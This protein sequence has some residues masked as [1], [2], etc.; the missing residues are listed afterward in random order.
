MK[1]QV[2]Y[3]VNN[4]VAIKVHVVNGE[5]VKITDPYTGEVYHEKV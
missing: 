5:I 4:G 2:F 1:T 3:K